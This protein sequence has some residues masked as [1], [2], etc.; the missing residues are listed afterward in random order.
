MKIGIIGG[1]PAGLCFAYLMKQQNPAHDIVVVE[2]NPRGATWGFGVVFSGTALD[3]VRGADDAIFARLIARAQTW[4]DLT[5]ALGDEKVAIDGNRFA[6]VS[7]LA[8]LEELVRLC[9]AR[10]I[11]IEFDHRCA[12]PAQFGDCD[13]IVGAD[14]VNSSV[15]EAQPQAFGTNT[16]YLT[17][18]FVWYGT[19]QVFDTLTLTFRQNGD[20]KF[21]AHHYRYSPD[22]STFIV[23]CDAA[24]FQRAGLETMSDRASRTYCEALFANDLGGHGLISNMS[25]WRRFPVIT[26]D[27]WTH[28]NMVLIGDALR[29]AHF[30]IGS[31]T[32]L[33]MADA[34]ALAAAF[35]KAGDD[36]GA[37]FAEFERVRRPQA[38]TLRKAAAGSYNWYENFA[39]KF[40]LSALELAYDYMTRSG[41]VDDARLRETSPEF[42]AKYDAA[43]LR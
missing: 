19:R 21:V 22:M 2:Q 25:N 10:D 35:Q 14:G 20:G 24:T 23:E 39:R 43:K 32:R 4:D 41:R 5:I 31:G 8:L 7:R 42:M 12:D 37:A 18:A 36:V 27:N 16:H 3:H 9:Q 30:S 1:G 29:T 38:E 33:A 13:L 15:R 28:D 34:A 6:A 17:N 11:D 26:N 40:D